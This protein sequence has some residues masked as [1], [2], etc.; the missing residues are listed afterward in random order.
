[1]VTVDLVDT[2]DNTAKIGELLTPQNLKNVGFTR[3][4][5]L[6]LG[7][8]LR[9]LLPRKQAEKLAAALALEGSE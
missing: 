3:R 2:H 4:H 7:A 8:A 5:G 6:A 9:M 1:V